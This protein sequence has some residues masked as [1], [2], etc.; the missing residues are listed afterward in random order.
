MALEDYKIS[1][2]IVMCW[3]SDGRLNTNI[4]PG[5]L[6]VNKVSTI[7]PQLDNFALIKGLVLDGDS[8]K[9]YSKVEGS[10]YL[11]C[12]E[13]KRMR[14]K[15]KRSQVASPILNQ[16]KK[17]IK[18]EGFVWD[19]SGGIYN[20][21]TN[22]F[23]QNQRSYIGVEEEH[24]YYHNEYP[25][26]K[27]WVEIYPSEKKFLLHWHQP[28]VELT[29]DNSSFM[30]NLCLEPWV[31]GELDEKVYDGFTEENLEQFKKDWIDYKNHLIGRLES[32]KKEVEEK[33]TLLNTSY[34]DIVKQFRNLGY[35]EEDHNYRYYA[36]SVENWYKIKKLDSNLS[37]RG[38][39]SFSKTFNSS[40]SYQLQ[41]DSS[42][43]LYQGRDQIW[44]SDTNYWYYN[45]NERNIP[46]G[47]TPAILNSILE[48]HKGINSIEEANKF[49]NKGFEA[50]DDAFSDD[51]IG[52]NGQES[53]SLT[54]AF[55]R[56]REE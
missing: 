17:Y 46:K 54:E 5:N 53:L 36:G 29:Q 9:Q 45:T 18:E 40:N 16:L 12:D 15:A 43:A 26:E 30:L 35:T 8:F 6:K 1:N 31:N 23:S 13:I 19:P 28:T 32:F 14:L 49:I 22:K 24:S 44:K 55:S 51:E 56:L 42:F 37:L 3:D 10:L 50:Y 25:L 2:D 48:E 38:I 52:F 21:P 39:I 47:L 20:A 41:Y 11:M 7:L 4:W 33:K 27:C 34:T